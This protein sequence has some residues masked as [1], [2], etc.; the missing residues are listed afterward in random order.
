MFDVESVRRI[1]QDAA[2][3]QSRMLKVAGVVLGA[4]GSD[5]VELLVTIEGCR[6]DPCQLSLGVFRNV[7]EAALKHAVSEQLR[8]H[9]EAHRSD[10][11]AE[12]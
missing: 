8:R 1:A 9:L 12:S 4:G 3:E 2:R 6:A 10:H 7:S 5:Y 11:S